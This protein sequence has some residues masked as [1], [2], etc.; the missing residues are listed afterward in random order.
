MS[1]Q[2]PA[3]YST[4]STYQAEVPQYV[5]PSAESNQRPIIGECGHCKGTIRLGDPVVEFFNGVATV[6]QQNGQMLAEAHPNEMPKS[7]TVHRTPCSLEYCMNEICP[8][9]SD[10]IIGEM[11]NEMAAEMMDE[12]LASWGITWDDLF[13]LLRSAGYTNVDEELERRVNKDD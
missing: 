13:D 11:S 5:A 6:S 3:P 4:D 9:D 10:E 8:D 7:V 2:A 12:Y 1:R